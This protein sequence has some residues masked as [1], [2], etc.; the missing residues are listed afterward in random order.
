M[1]RSTP[2]DY[3]IQDPIFTYPS[4]YGEHKYVVSTTRSRCSSPVNFSDY[5]NVLKEIK[6]F[7]MNSSPSSSSSSLG[8]MQGNADSFGGNLSTH[9]RF[10]YFN[11]R[12]GSREVPCG[13]FKK[14]PVRDSDQ[15]AMEKCSSVVVVSAIF[16]DHD[17]IRQPR[18]LGSKTLE[19]V[20]FFMFICYPESAR[21]PWIDF[22]KFQ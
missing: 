22:K 21:T 14:F 4:S 3:P 10:S 12:S 16:N 9:L 8:Y 11:R 13:F 7:Q 15:I 17:K 20:C 18:G 2:F 1:L 19:T 5:R 6:H